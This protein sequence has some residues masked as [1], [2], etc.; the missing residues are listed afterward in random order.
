MEVEKNDGMSAFP[1]MKAALHSGCSHCRLSA[2]CLVYAAR[3]QQSVRG[4]HHIFRTSRV[5]KNH[6]VARRPSQSNFIQIIRFGQFKK[7]VKDLRGTER[8]GGFRATGELL[9]IEILPN[10]LDELRFTAIEDSEICEIQIPEI[11]NILCAT[12]A[13]QKKLLLHF[14]FSLQQEQLYA[15]MLTTLSLDDR[16]EEFLFGLGDRYAALGYS[17]KTFRLSMS[18]SDMASYL[19]TTVETISRIIARFNRQGRAI[20]EGREVKL[21]DRTLR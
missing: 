2:I 16:F 20:I 11:E 14:T 9:G 6:S 8:I 1:G 7:I 12:P 13:I 3:E 18:R 19:G 10:V 17:G 4:G 15:S 21:I 5:P